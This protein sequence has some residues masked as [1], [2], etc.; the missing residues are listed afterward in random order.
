[1]VSAMAATLTFMNGI[2]LSDGAII[3]NLNALK[4]V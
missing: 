1:M 3:P 4:R 2:I